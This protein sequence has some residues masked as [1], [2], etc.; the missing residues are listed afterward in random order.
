MIVLMDYGV[1]SRIGRE[2]YLEGLQKLA[3]IW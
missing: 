3:N 1:E 2:D